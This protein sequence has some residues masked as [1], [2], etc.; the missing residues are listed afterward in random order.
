MV[1]GSSDELRNRTLPSTKTLLEPPVW[2]E[3]GSSLAPQFWIVQ[4]QSGL[5][6]RSIDADLVGRPPSRGLRGSAPGPPIG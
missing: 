2:N 6:G 5:G 4:G 1:I 3:N